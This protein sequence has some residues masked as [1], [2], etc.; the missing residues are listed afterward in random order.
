MRTV[1]EGE[2]RGVVGKICRGKREEEDGLVAAFREGCV[3]I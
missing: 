3:Y 1:Y 2:Y